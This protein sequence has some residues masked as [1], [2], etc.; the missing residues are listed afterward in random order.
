MQTLSKLALA[1]ILLSPWSRL[2]AQAALT[3]A[4]SEASLLPLAKKG[5]VEAEY[6][7]GMLYFK[8]WTDT[9]KNLDKAVPWLIKAA[10][11]GHPHANLVLG[12]LYEEGRGVPKNAEE[13]A[14]RNRKAEVL[15]QTA[16]NKGDVKAQKILGDMYFHGWGVA[17]DEKAAIAWYSKAATNGNAE[18]M[19]SI[20]GVYLDMEKFEDAAKWLKM[21]AEAG[22]MRAQC[23]LGGL[24]LNGVGVPKDVAEG[25]KWTRMAAEKGDATA[26]FNLGTCYR[27]GQGVPKDEQK[28]K[29]WFDKAQGSFAD[30]E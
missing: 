28:A 30:K 21:G 6:K 1:L 8:E 27:D 20:G 13:S 10:D 4:P 18:A 3:N 2:D 17:K 11:H 23:N 24:Y 9:Q 7:W 15:Y 5:E 16:A 12:G 29:E 22:D 26:Q 19:T 14:K 25:I